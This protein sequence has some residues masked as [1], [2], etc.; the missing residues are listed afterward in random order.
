MKTPFILLFLLSICS[1]FGQ[2]Y[3]SLRKDFLEERDTIHLEFKRDR[4]CI[5]LNPELELY[6]SNHFLVDYFKYHK[7]ILSLKIITHQDCRGTTEKNLEISQRRA[8]SIKEFLLEYV[9]SNM[10][11]EA[12]GMGENMPYTAKTDSGFT[13]LDCK[14]ISTKTTKDEQERL[15]QLNRR[16]EFVVIKAN[17]EAWLEREWTD[18]SHR[19]FSEIEV[20]N[21]YLFPEISFTYSG[22]GSLQANDSIN[23][24]DSVLIMI[25]FL[26]DHPEITKVE[27]GVHSDC[28]GSFE[29]NQKLSE[30]RAGVV[31]D[32]FVYNGIPPEMIET[33]GYGESKP[34]YDNNFHRKRTCDWIKGWEDK[35]IM[36]N[37]HQKN[38]RV[39]L[40]ILEVKKE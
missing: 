32:E 19:F 39:E 29:N 15:H 9:D 24:I 40:K 30:R 22:G 2:E 18:Y 6:Q 5:R 31:K 11:I 3:T 26:K 12:I 17:S 16:T 33:K 8:E 37:M 10:K 4:S 35:E 23:S 1:S 28:R 13:A 34:S 7:E 25:H 36:E 14:L 20:G 27:I 21:L 38:R